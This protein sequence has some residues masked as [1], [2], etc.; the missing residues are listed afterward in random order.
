[1]HGCRKLMLMLEDVDEDEDEDVS[2]RLLAV[3]NVPRY[4]DWMFHWHFPCITQGYLDLVIIVGA[5]N[6]VP[7]ATNTF[8]AIQG[9]VAQWLGH[10]M[11]YHLALQCCSLASCPRLA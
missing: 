10:F 11:G 9:A 3:S 7:C 8:A 1:M 4:G 2:S 5:W 6:L